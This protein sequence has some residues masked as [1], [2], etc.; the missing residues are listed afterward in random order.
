MNEIQWMRISLI[1]NLRKWTPHRIITHSP[2]FCV[3]VTRKGYDW[4]FFFNNLRIKLNKIKINTI[5]SFWIFNRT[6]IF[7]LVNLSSSQSAGLHPNKISFLIERQLFIVLFF[8]FPWFF[9]QLNVNY[10]LFTM[11]LF[12]I[13]IITNG[14][15]QHKSKVKL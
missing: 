2:W 14:Q 1:F 3:W 11:N 13:F 7:Q 6:S 8:F 5:K 10:L 9:F 15:R 4:I 12:A